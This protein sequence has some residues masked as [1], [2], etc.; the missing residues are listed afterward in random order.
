MNNI[1]KEFNE[2][3]LSDIEI[4]QRKLATGSPRF[5]AP[6]DQ[7]VYENSQIMNLCSSFLYYYMLIEMAIKNIK[8][9]KDDKETLKDIHETITEHHK[10][11]KIIIDKIKELE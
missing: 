11:Y 8:I 9:Y 5:G 10:Q 2:R 3:K 1:I 4:V 7:I 6:I